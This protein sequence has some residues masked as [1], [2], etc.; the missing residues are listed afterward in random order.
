MAGVNLKLKREDIIPY[1][2]GALIA[3]CL[4]LLVSG[5]GVLVDETQFSTTSQAYAIDSTYKIGNVDVSGDMMNALSSG[6]YFK[7]SYFSGRSTVLVTLDA[8]EGY[9]QCPF[10]KR[11]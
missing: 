7:C 6:H 3:F 2:L 1:S 8:R 4:L 11:V 10:L 5:F 9:H